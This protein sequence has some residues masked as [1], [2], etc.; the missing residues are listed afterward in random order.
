MPDAV[1][2]GQQGHDNIPACQADLLVPLFPRAIEANRGLMEQGCLVPCTGGS[3]F[4]KRVYLEQLVL[5]WSRK[6]EFTFRQPR[7]A[8]TLLEGS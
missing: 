7:F 4:I 5:Y 6:L 2:P 8:R 3:I 1:Q